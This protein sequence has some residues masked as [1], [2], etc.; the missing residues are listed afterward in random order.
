MNIFETLGRL[1]AE[2]DA[3]PL[4]CT[5]GPEFCRVRVWSA[6]RWRATPSRLRPRRA[7]WVEGLGWVVALPVQNLN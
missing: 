7:E 3:V 6:A 2:S 5:D 4:F 1:T